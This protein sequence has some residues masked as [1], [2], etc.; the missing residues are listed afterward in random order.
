MKKKI[1][2]IGLGNIGMMYDYDKNGSYTLTY[3]TAL[4]RSKKLD[5]IGAVDISKKKRELFEKKFQIKSFSTPKKLFEKIKPDIVIISTPTNKHLDIIKE[6][7]KLKKNLVIICEKPLT[8][9]Y[10]TIM[11]LE[12]LVKKNK[13]KV[14]TNYMRLFDPKFLSIKKYFE[15]N[16][17]LNFFCEVFYNGSLLNS[18]SHY[19][20]LI[21]T[22][23]G[24]NYKIKILKIKKNFCDFKLIYKNS[25]IYF[26][27][28]SIRN[29]QYEDIRLISKNFIFTYKNGGQE[30]IK[31]KSII[32]P[33][34]KS[35]RNYVRIKKIKDNF[36]KNSQ[37][38]TIKEIEKLFDNKKRLIADLSHA[39]KVQNLI[40]NIYERK[41]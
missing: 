16:K 22:L 34:Y 2:L 4:K 20:S 40:K 21:I 31:E 28:S 36:Y 17:K 19:I 25:E 35:G 11:K 29:L 18:C 12:N 10:N 37:K 33:I 5:F 9:N 32:N 7:I 41:K 39:K 15:E 38:F 1:A 24:N 6:L 8:K 30:I 27:S 26:Y 13:N 3:A 14:Y 23:F